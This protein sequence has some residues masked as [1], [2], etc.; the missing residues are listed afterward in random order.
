MFLTFFTTLTGIRNVDPAL[1]D[2]ARL[3]GANERQIFRYVMLLAAAAWVIN[4]LKEPPL[5]FDWGHRK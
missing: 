5:R 3:V 4:G 1:A 2:V